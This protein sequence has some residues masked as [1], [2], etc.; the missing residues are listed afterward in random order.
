MLFDDAAPF[1]FPIGEK[2]G[3]NPFIVTSSLTKVYGLSGLRC[4]W[5]LAS[6]DLAHRMWRLNDLFAATAAHAAERMSV[7]AF[8]HIG[9]FRARAQTLLSS[10]RAL[11]DQFL[12]SRTDL[13][14]VRPSGGSVVFP[15]LTSGDVDGF[16]RLLREKYETTVVPGSFFGSP[17]H[18]RVGI[19]GETPSLRGGLERLTAALDEFG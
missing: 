19:G 3:T 8:D 1:C 2:L 13:E 18:F 7:M 10:N 5:I 12:D 14:C 11:L 15:R 16:C 17:Q 4:G 6:P 9:K